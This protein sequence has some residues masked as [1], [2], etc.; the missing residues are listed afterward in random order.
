M[1]TNVLKWNQ[2]EQSFKQIWNKAYSNKTELK[3]IV[4][5]LL[6]NSHNLKY[7]HKNVFNL[8]LP[9]RYEI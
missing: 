6:M 8:Q 5:I 3:N 2:V 7:E 9:K 4:F 1:Y